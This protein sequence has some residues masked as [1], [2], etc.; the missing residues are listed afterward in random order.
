MTAGVLAGRRAAVVLAIVALAGL[1][2]LSSC[3]DG[4]TGAGSEPAA[5]A[6]TTSS[7]PAR[8]APGTR[9]DAKGLPRPVSNLVALDDLVVF[10][11]SDE[12]GE[13]ELVAV[14]PVAGKVRW[15]RSAA[16]AAAGAG[17]S[18]D[19]I[20]ADGA[21]LAL[22]R[23]GSGDLDYRTEAIESDGLVRW[24]VAMDTPLGYPA[25][26]GDR[27][28][29]ATRVGPVAIDAETGEHELGRD[30][31][32]GVFA[33]SG[34]QVL[35]HEVKKA[36]PGVH[37][38]IAEPRFGDG[39][40]WRRALVDLIGSSASLDDLEGW[41][42]DVLGDLWIAQF[43][44]DEERDVLSFSS[45]SSVMAGFRV[46]D[47][48]PRWHRSGL[49]PCRLP[50]AMDLVVTCGQTS[51]RPT[52]EDDFTVITT[53]VGV[54]DPSTGADRITVTTDPYDTA[55]GDR[56][57]VVGPDRLALR[58]PTGIELVDLRAATSTAG[59]AGQIAWCR[60]DGHLPEV[61]DHEGNARA[62]STAA[63]G[64]PCTVD[65]REATEDE[66]LAPIIDGSLPPVDEVSA[67]GIGPWV[68][69]NQDGRL[70]G[71]ATEA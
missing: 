29:V 6:T 22:D 67:I 26:C 36:E 54:L 55:A 28:C 58:T 35:L 50:V 65:A 51:S 70:S 68:L 53:G 21:V 2:G 17:S 34:D 20:A 25:A 45:E 42:G 5:D 27:I 61:V 64:R 24:S 1:L 43:D 44:I 63:L 41:D 49:A 66:L 32:G 59:T 23:R 69:W 57:A 13:L 30:W 47:G 19:L 4:S 39:P 3:T 15:R 56:F 7:G 46:S 62:H 37:D 33:A 60:P 9:F 31:S 8:P 48:D 14:D 11:A 52:A 71:V 16:V 18:I 38:V 12:D 10:Y 40:G